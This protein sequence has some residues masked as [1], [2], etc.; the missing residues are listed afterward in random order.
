VTIPELDYVE[1]STM[2]GVTPVL[3]VSFFQFMVFRFRPYHLD[4]TEY[5]QDPSI[6]GI[7]VLFSS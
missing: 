7:E 2:K 3:Q 4:E 1:D 5:F 6:T